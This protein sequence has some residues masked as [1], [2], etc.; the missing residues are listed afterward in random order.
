MNRI[1]ILVTFGLFLSYTLTPAQNNH[2]AVGYAA[3]QQG[4]YLTAIKE[5]NK[6]VSG[7]PGAEKDLKRVLNVLLKKYQ[8]SRDKNLEVFILK[9]YNETKNPVFNSWLDAIY[10]KIATSL[11]NKQ[12]IRENS[13]NPIA[14]AN[15]IQKNLEEAIE[16]IEFI[17]KLCGQ[18][19]LKNKIK[20][21][22]L[23]RA[24][25]YEIECPYE[26][27]EDKKIDKL[28]SA[29]QIY[30][31]YSITRKGLATKISK[32]Y[33]SAF[34]LGSYAQYYE[35]APP[36][37]NDN[38]YKVVFKAG[39]NWLLDS[40]KYYAKQAEDF[41]FFKALADKTRDKAKKEKNRI[42]N[43][44]ITIEYTDYTPTLL[45]RRPERTTTTINGESDAHYFSDRGAETITIKVDSVN[46]LKNALSVYELIG[47]KENVTRCKLILGIK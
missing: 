36:G 1:V 26:L 24:K 15:K 47:D 37:P 30:Q 27:F 20:Q 10:K 7:F 31:K 46:Y 39:D 43:T 11:L 44:G 22:D 45:G 33:L 16:D 6:A 41:S 17:I 2:F 9:T 3:E 40:A 42:Y 14:N 8:K 19:P 38:L 23:V 12:G 13:V 32:M 35:F 34:L 29:F 21:W 25:L 18:V 28:R 4:K 5:Y